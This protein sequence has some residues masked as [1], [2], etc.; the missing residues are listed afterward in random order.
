MTEAIRIDGV[1]K[2]F[3][4][5][6][7]LDNISLSFNFGE[8]HA[9]CGENGAGKSTLM[10]IIGGVY[11]SDGGKIWVRG[12]EAQIRTPQEAFR[13]GIGIVH[14]EL[15]LCENMP[16][17]HNVFVNREHT[18]PLGFIRRREMQEQTKAVLAK[19]NMQIDPRTRV[20]QLPFA[21]RQMIEIAKILSMNIDVLILDEPTS[22]LS[23]R[24]S[25]ALFELLFSLREQGKAIIF[26]SHKLD[27][28]LQISDRVTVLRDGSLVGTMTAKEATTAKIVSMMVG[29]DI[30]DLYPPKA[31]SRDGQ[32]VLE[33]SELSRKGKFSDISF[34]LR[35]GEIL[36]L[37][38]LVGSGRTE[39]AL[40]MV[41]ADKVDSGQLRL[42]GV[43]F[44]PRSPRQAVKNGV[45]YLSEDRKQLGLFLEMPL[46]DNFVAASLE[47]VTGSFGVVQRKQVQD[48]TEEL[49]EQ[50]DVVPKRSD[51]LAGRL[52]GG[53]Q[54]KVLLGKWLA[55]NP[56]VLIVDEP[57]RGVDVGAK[58]RIHFLLR[59]LAD[60][61]MAVLMISSDLPEVLGLSDR[62]MVMHEGKQQGILENV[63]LTQEIVMNVAYGEK[64][65]TA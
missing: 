7:V 40:S 51:A 58:S 3:S 59:E 38:G 23:E 45:C 26:I 53:N 35:A 61:G 22:A 65:E 62:V 29:R 12:E 39:L 56:R 2:S 49:I 15:S 34:E 33:V 54:Q 4:G 9:I 44:A 60:Q 19:L 47:R 11:H 36:G 31:K 10:K 5:N 55:A 20:S 42:D 24:E 16:V 1:S 32:V 25:Q 21:T 52:S 18:G 30:T 27:E 50:L 37:Y 63:D 48:I 41:G 57:S 6:R 46:T 14:Q 17:W 43:L 28:V 8:I 13:H 64:V